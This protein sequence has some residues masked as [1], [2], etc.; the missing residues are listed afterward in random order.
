MSYPHPSYEKRQDFYVSQYGF[1]EKGEAAMNELHE[2]AKALARSCDV[3][4]QG[5]HTSCRSN[6]HSDPSSSVSLGQAIVDNQP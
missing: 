6:K 4:A 1:V 5:V 3:Q 2:V